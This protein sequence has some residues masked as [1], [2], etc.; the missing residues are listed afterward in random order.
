MLLQLVAICCRCLYSSTKSII[1]SCLMPCISL[2]TASLSIS[3]NIIR[4]WAHACFKQ[5]VV[6]PLTVPIL[7][8]HHHCD[9]TSVAELYATFSHRFACV[10]HLSDS[11]VSA[12]RTPVDRT[13][14]V[15][16]NPSSV[17]GF[18]CKSTRKLSMRRSCWHDR[19]LDLTWHNPEGGYYHSEICFSSCTQSITFADLSGACRFSSVEWSII[20]IFLAYSATLISSCRWLLVSDTILDDWRFLSCLH[21]LGGHYP[22]VV[23]LES[24]N[25]EWNEHSTWGEEQPR[26]LL[27]WDNF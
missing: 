18:C 21:R 15:W 11:T 10:H 13:L 4:L 6:S 7:S 9:N 2:S 8:H 14:Y 22:V 3:C 23:F 5:R 27:T 16:C 12:G 26:K 25:F 1:K 20:A 17:D 19:G 24:P